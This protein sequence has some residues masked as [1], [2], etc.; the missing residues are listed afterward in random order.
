[1]IRRV[2]ETVLTDIRVLAVDQRTDDSESKAALAKTATLEVTPKQAEIIAVVSELG[3]LSLS[4]RSLANDVP[5]DVRPAS[6]AFTFDSEASRLLKRK[7]ETN[8]IAVKVVR[9]GATSAVNFQR[10]GNQGY[11]A[12]GGFVANGGATAAAQGLQ[13][14]ANQSVSDTA[15]GVA[16]AGN[17]TEKVN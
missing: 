2:T 10:D 6:K 5:E 11:V 7:S 13:N 14:G 3:R 1:M 9:G 4:L 8:V 15:G 16:R 12:T 17:L